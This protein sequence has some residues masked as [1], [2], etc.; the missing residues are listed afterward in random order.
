MPKVEQ[1][2]RLLVDYDLEKATAC[3]GE[4]ITRSVASAVERIEAHAE[5]DQ[6][7]FRGSLMLRVRPS[8]ALVAALAVPGAFEVSGEGEGLPPGFVAAALFGGS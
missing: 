4:A 2:Q 6:R 3:F 7:A 8:A 5:V 1:A